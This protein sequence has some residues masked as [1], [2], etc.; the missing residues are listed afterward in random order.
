LV[1]QYAIMSALML[2]FKNIYLAGFDGF[3]VMNEEQAD[4]ERFFN[5]LNDSLKLDMVLS[6]TPT[7]YNIK[8]IS[9]FTLI[10]DE[11]VQ[12]CYSS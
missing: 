10:Q 8:E 2:G 1:G 12:S 11:K 7:K 9:P 6:L 4:M 5:S 3:S